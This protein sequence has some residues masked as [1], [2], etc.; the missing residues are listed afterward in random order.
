MLSSEVIPVHIVTD[1]YDDL[2]KETFETKKF[3]ANYL[4]KYRKELS[5]NA[6]VVLNP[7]N[8]KQL[9]A[10]SKGRLISI[11]LLTENTSW[12]SINDYIK[13]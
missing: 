7:E 9:I 3:T 5:L 13:H 8:K 4:A 11:T 1:C 10:V 6:D 12:E 2:S